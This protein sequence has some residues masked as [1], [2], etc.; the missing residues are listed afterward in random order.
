MFHRWMK[1]GWPLVLA[2]VGGSAVAAQGPTPAPGCRPPG[3]LKDVVPGS[4]SSLP[5][6]PSV[7]SFFVRVGDTV[8]FA[9]DDGEH[10]VELWKSDG[11]AA[12]TV[13]VKDINPLGESRPRNLTVL[14]GKVFFYADDGSIGSE[15][16]MSDGTESGTELVRQ[17]SPGMES[18]GIS[19]MVT[20]GGRLYFTA[21]DHE[22]GSELWVS[23]GTYSGT[24]RLT[25]LFAGA[26]SSIQPG[27]LTVVGDTLFFSAMNSP[28]VGYELWKSNGTTAGTVLV[29]DIA[30]GEAGSN[31]G[32]MT[33]LGSTLFFTANNG[34]T[35]DDLWRSDGTEAGTVRVKAVFSQALHPSP[36]NLKAVGGRLFFSLDDKAHGAELWVSNG[37]PEGTVMVRDVR[38]DVDGS[39]PES[40][41]DLGGTLYFTAD[42]GLTGREL[43][44]SDG[45]EGGTRLV[46]DL[47]M[48]SGGSSPQGLTAGGGQLFFAANDGTGLALWMSDG[49]APGTRRVDPSSPSPATWPE[50]L[51][52]LDGALYYSAEAA[53]TGREPYVVFPAFFGDCTPPLITCPAGVTV[54]AMS[55][56]GT[57][58]SYASARARDEGATSP[59]VS[60]SHASGSTF[61]LG[62]NA[63]TATATDAAGN[64]NTCTF[65]VAVKDTRA[66]TLTCPRD[67]VVSATGN[68]G[69]VARYPAAQ[70]TDNTAL[71]LLYST[72]SGSTFPVGDTE[73]RVTARDSGG[74]TVS[75]A[76][77]VKVNAAQGGGESK[78]SGCGCTSGFTA[79]APWLLLGLLAP[80]LARR[81][82]SSPF[83][84]T[85]DHGE[86]TWN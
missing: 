84:E 68:E 27:T 39:N 28:D 5:L 9:A 56:S 13:M 40:F 71:S 25:D 78:D 65:T 38:A 35:D 6:E 14:N 37:T 48:G 2:L 57:A 63:V 20:L 22:T 76:F 52:F 50:H 16:W 54:E 33:V 61:A 72:P 17:I 80:L 23:D 7:T 70:A 83:R 10:G 41:A 77:N 86:R 82:R 49:T 32:Q 53:S 69:A 66:P 59:A 12:G 74:N 75:C 81:R 51:T 46:K 30:P 43:W 85:R 62:D 11:T 24:T 60:Y 64:T 45:T 19:D 55:A 36:Q 58:V 73:V 4:A 8:Y 47:V 44:K 1:Y 21:N 79:D 34:L 18:A 42:N 29:K 3:L 31:I 15:L 26:E 67:V